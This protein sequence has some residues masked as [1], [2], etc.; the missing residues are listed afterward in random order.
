MAERTCDNGDHQRTAIVRIWRPADH[1][2]LL[3]MH[4]LTSSYSFDPS[5]QYVIGVIGR[6]PLY[7]TRG[8]SRHVLQ[9]GDLGVWDPGA[10]HAGSP[11]NERMWE[12]R[13]IVVEWPDLHDLAT[14]PEVSV[15]DLWFPNPVIRDQRLTASFLRL[16]QSMADPAPT[17]ERDDSLASFLQELAAHS[18]TAAPGR[19]GRR[20]VH[21]HI[22]LRRAC[23]LMLDNLTTNVSLDELARAAETSAFQLVR[24]FRAR[25]GAPPHA[26][27]IGQ[28]IK[29]ARRLL[30][31]GVSPSETALECGFFDQSHL[32]RHFRRRTGLSPSRYASVF[33][34]APSGP[35]PD[36]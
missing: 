15:R 33:A 14:D 18:P 11:A 9:P 2:R 4:G 34:S 8:R 1:P 5:G 12:C 27:Q 16:H 25:L 35:L 7:A 19:P 22:A 31:R 32:T 21:D 10:A 30:E 28:R 23:E 36:A 17:L 26:F 20:E 13:L 24:L 29:L 6:A 3:L